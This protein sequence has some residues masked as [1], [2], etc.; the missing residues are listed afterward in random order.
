MIADPD[1]CH[2]GAPYT[3]VGVSHNCGENPTL[4]TATCPVLVLLPFGGGASGQAFHR[5]LRLGTQET[6]H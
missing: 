1:F 5:S 4:D 2:T 3:A 6:F